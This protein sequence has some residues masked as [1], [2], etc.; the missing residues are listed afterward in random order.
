MTDSKVQVYFDKDYKIR[1]LDPTKFEKTEQL[2][3]ECG[4]FVEKIGSF[5]EKIHTLVEVLEA[6]TTRIDA[7]KLR[8]C[9]LT[10]SSCIYSG[11]ID[12]FVHQSQISIGNWFENG[13]RK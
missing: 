1:L 7:Q 9:K 10:N 3:K 8:V 5:N 11:L 13:S 2:E 6:H 4:A 12:T